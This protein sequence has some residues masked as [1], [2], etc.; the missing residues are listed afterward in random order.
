M[1]KTF[2]EGRQAAWTRP[3]AALPTRAPLF[4]SA[5]LKCADCRL[6]FPQRQLLANHVRRKH[7][8]AVTYQCTHCPSKFET[9][10]SLQAHIGQYRGDDCDKGFSHSSHL[11]VHRRIHRGETP[12]R[13]R[14]CPE[15]FI[16]SNHLRVHMKSHGSQLPFACGTCKA[17]FSQKRQMV[18]HSN[19]AHGSQVVEETSAE[20]VLPPSCSLSPR[21]W[22]APTSPMGTAP[23]RRRGPTI[24]RRGSTRRSRGAPWPGLASPPSDPPPPQLRARTRRGGP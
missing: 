9:K 2:Q 22:P 10:K 1:R 20:V 7:P 4:E 18:N 12:Y 5:S 19:T 15:G 24:T 21:W 11:A 16:S 13:C 23:P 14:P 3:P 6:L 8:K 17:T